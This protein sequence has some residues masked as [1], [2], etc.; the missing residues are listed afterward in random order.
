MVSIRKFRIFQWILID[1]HSFQ[2]AAHDPRLGPAVAADSDYFY[3]LG[4]QVFGKLQGGV[5]GATPAALVILPRNAEP[6]G[7][8]YS[9]P[10]LF[11]GPV[12]G[13]TL[14]ASNG[15]IRICNDDG[16]VGESADAFHQQVEVFPDDYVQ[17]KFEGTPAGGIV[18]VV[19][20]PSVSDQAPFDADFVVGSS[21]SGGETGGGG[22]DGDDDGDG[23]VGTQPNP[24]LTSFVATV[25][26]DPNASKASNAVTY[27]GPDSTVTLSGDPGATMVRCRAS[28]C[29]AP[30]TGSLAVK[31]GDTIAVSMIS[32]TFLEVRTAT[33]SVLGAS[34]QWSLTTRK[35]DDRPDTIVIARAIN[36]PPNTLYEDPSSHTLGGFDGEQEML[37][38][39]NDQFSLNGGPWIQ[40]A[41]VKSGDVVKVRSISGPAD[42]VMV[43]GFFINGYTSA[44]D[45]WVGEPDEEE[46]S[47]EVEERLVQTSGYELE[48]VVESEEIDPYI[49]WDTTVNVEYGEIS[50]NGGE[51]TSGQDIPYMSGQTFRF[52]ATSSGHYT[53]STGGSMQFED[54]DMKQVRYV[55]VV[56]T[57]DA[58]YSATPFNFERN[59]TPA[60]SS[61]LSEWK[62]ITGIDDH[63]EVGV[64]VKLVN[65]QQYDQLQFW[66]R[67]QS[68][69]SSQGNFYDQGTR[70]GLGDKVRIRT[71]RNPG[72][73]AT[74]EFG[75]KVGY[76][77]FDPFVAKWLIFP[78]TE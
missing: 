71:S 76:D 29:T 50:I 21:T 15:T 1:D 39:D 51:W 66:Y 62:E 48:V 18:R 40:Q 56:D 31:E 59:V 44:W 61:S 33:I 13:A 42:G 23:G 11:R 60:S 57:R 64:D 37:S 35:I 28:A 7:P 32:G 53:S 9:V 78:Q 52:R 6:T 47:D 43:A 69:P 63:Y 27:S 67:G 65:P 10:S 26:A 34:K 20:T 25:D 58:D 12:S 72:A 16:C 22:G 77:G 2:D 55:Y 17:V 36:L 3:R 75:I 54:S 4:P 68:E 41:M 74:L 8:T 70:L 45:L 73:G 30:A 19:V 24:G 46:P 38:L 49:Y 14:L 5:P